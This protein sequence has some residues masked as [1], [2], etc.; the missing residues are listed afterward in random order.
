MTERLFRSGRQKMIGGVCGGLADYFRIDV[1]LVRL[2]ALLTLFMGGA[3]FF[4]YLV[5]WVVVPLNPDHQVG[6]A[7]QY[8]RGADTIISDI[9]NDVE[10]AAQNFKKDN[11]HGGQGTK[12]AGGFLII[13]GVI[14]MLDQWFPYWFSMSKMWPFVLIIIGVAIIWRGKR[15]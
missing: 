5:M 13:L 1:T 14:F 10:E 2:L 3:G 4:A 6:Y 8:S 15:R 12:F 9:V 7:R 11:E